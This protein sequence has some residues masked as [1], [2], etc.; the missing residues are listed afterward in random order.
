MVHVMGVMRPPNHPDTLG[1]DGIDAKQKEM[2]ENIENVIKTLSGNSTTLDLDNGHNA[3]TTDIELNKTIGAEKHGDKGDIGDS[4]EKFED[5]AGANR[6]PG[7]PIID[8][9]RRL[10]K[11]GF[12]LYGRRRS[13]TV[14]SEIPEYSTWNPKTPKKPEEKN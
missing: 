9:F 14:L 8:P 7:K 5:Q 10:A 4:L 3:E 6:K 2:P 1:F 13:I 11:P 12:S